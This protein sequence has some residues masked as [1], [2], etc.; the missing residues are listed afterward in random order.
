LT[1]RILTEQLLQA[2]LVGHDEF[3]KSCKELDQAMSIPES[4][5]KDA[6]HKDTSRFH[7]IIVGSG[8]GGGPLA[9]RLALAG[10]RVLLIEAGSDPIEAK[11]SPAY[12]DA[13]VG[14]VTRVP[15]YY[16]AAS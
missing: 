9:A 10:K 3:L 14:E 4:L 7:Y 1:T 6:Q 16:A 13:D 8:A 15:A 5:L 12:P 2:G 11:P